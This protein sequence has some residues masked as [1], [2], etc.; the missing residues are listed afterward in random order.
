DVILSVPSLRAIRSKFENANIKVLVGLR[1]RE[2]L[3]GCPYINDTIVCDLK[4]RDRAYSGL[5]RVGAALR[6]NCF[7]MVIDLQNN[8][9]SHILAFSSLAHLRYG[10]DNR[11]LS[12][13][14]N[15]RIKD[16]APYLDPIEHQFRVLNA[17][18]I[19]GSG[20]TLELWPSANDDKYVDK[21][22]ADNWI[23]PSQDLVGI[24]VRA[25]AKWATKNWPPSYIA[26]LC[27]RL[28]KEFNIR[29]VLTGSKDD[30][31]F[32]DRIVKSTAA[33]PVVAVG[34][35]GLLEL[36]SLVKRFK[37]YLTPDSAPMHIAAAMAT[38][39]VALF[40]PTDPRRHVPA[41]KDVVVLKKDLRCSPCYSSRCMK[42]LR[43]MRKI[44]V[45]EVL[46]AMKKFLIKEAT[47]E[48][49]TV[50]DAH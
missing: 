24:N 40:G 19:K 18:G 47:V 26:Q 38:P 37:V 25:S 14:L 21:F 11:K 50:N 32:T 3:N 2:A 5:M 43:C 20:K 46:N 15:R 12:F 49:I 17:A 1:S 13:L 36:A 31:D 30:I 39:F 27:D 7:D 48:N 23:K 35:T 4:G 22:L 45:D 33:K 42:D 44:T 10:Y 29:V 41:A 34:K 16:D 9:K 28:A 6:K 8:R